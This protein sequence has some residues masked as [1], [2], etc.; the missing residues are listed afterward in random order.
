MMDAQH[1][2]GQVQRFGF[3]LFRTGSGFTLRKL[4]P[5]ADLPHWL[6]GKLTAAKPA[7]IAW[8]DRIDLPATPREDVIVSQP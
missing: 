5:N 8:L 2:V 1:L 4:K 3:T 6:E 7:I